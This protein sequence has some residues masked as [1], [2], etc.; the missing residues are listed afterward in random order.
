M[1]RQSPTG[2]S[3]N[4]LQRQQQ[5]ATPS[6][7]NWRARIKKSSVA[8][9]VE[10]GAMKVKKPFAPMASRGWPIRVSDVGKEQQTIARL[11]LGFITVGVEKPSAAFKQHDHPVSVQH[12][13][14][15]GRNSGVARRAR[16]QQLTHRRIALFQKRIRDVKRLSLNSHSPL[17]CDFGARMHFFVKT[18]M[19]F[20][21]WNKDSRL[22]KRRE[23]N[24]QSVSQCA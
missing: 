6:F 13:H 1:R 17:S 4:L 18:N 8:P 9:Q 2:A 3:R 24:N 12:P 10:R 11:D 22:E 14:R 15:V 7:D 19:N 21:I 20:S 16:A 5:G 23:G